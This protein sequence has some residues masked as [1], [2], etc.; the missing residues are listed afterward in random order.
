MS[1]FL[2]GLFSAI[3]GFAAGI[4]FYNKEIALG[5]AVLAKA[6]GVYERAE[7]LVKKIENVF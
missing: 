3:G 6:Y 1:Y 7:S 4:I 5:R 2:T